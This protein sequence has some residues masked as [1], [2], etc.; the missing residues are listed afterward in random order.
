MITQI[1]KSIGLA[2]IVI[3]VLIALGLA[4]ITLGTLTVVGLFILVVGLFMLGARKGP[5]KIG[6]ALLAVGFIIFLVAY[7]GWL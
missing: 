3:V 6:I 7:M 4:F 2:I 5:P 1:V